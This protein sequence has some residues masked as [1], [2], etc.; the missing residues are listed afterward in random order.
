MPSLQELFSAQTWKVLFVWFHKLWSLVSTVLPAALLARL[1]S[2]LSA[3]SLSIL[4]V[5]SSGGSFPSGICSGS[6][7]N[8]S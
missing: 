7:E 2:L 3:L 8:L 4:S 1:I 6:A 5:L